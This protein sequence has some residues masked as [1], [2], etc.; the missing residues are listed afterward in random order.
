[1]SAAVAA[2]RRAPASPWLVLTLVCLAQ[3]MVI[4]D[5]TIVNVALP[6]LQ[7]DLHFTPS[8]LQWVVNA[9]TLLFG[10]FLLLGGRAG[11]LFG[12]KRLF[13]LG[14]AVFTAASL[15]DGIAPSSGTLIAARALQGLGAALVSPAALSIIT[16]T[17]PEGPLRTRAMGIWAS[18]A[19]GGGA[20]GLL[21]G[22]ILTEYA[23]WRWIFFVNVPVGIAT[24]LLATRF[25]PESRVDGRRGFD[26]AGAVTSTT[27]R[28]V[29]VYGIVKAQAYGWGSA[30]TLGLLGAAA[31]LLAVFVALELRSAQPLLRLGVFRRRSLTAGNAVMLVVAGGMFAIFFFATLYVQEI[32]HLSPV[33]AGLGFLPLTAGIVVASAVAQQLIGR[34][35]VRP[36]VLAG[37]LIAA[38][39]LLLLSRVSVDGS[40]A[41]DVLPGILVMAVGLGLTFVPLTLIATTGV[42]AD[43]AGLASGLFTSAQQIGGALGLAILSTLAAD[44]T[45]SDLAGAAT[46]HE[47]AAALVAG[48]HVAFVAGAGLL[49]AGVALMAGLVRARHV[50]AVDGVAGLPEAALEGDVG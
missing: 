18:I 23:S 45:A 44:R 26:V 9:Y 19:V 6:T 41:S 47:R 20:V 38:V 8:S 15:L 43:D 12:R 24:A 10:G 5:A 13:L 28:V 40:Y 7:R 35:G 34:A 4:L 27:G 37:M 50:H 46:A 36:V 33:Q 32:L 49:L 31:V 30:R 29:L 1:M 11:D 39:G 22:G 21:L 2:R 3:F 14:V 25:V 42:A 16:T 17:F 48:Y